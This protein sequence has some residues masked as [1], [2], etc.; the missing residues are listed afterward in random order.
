MAYRQ[1]DSAS[2]AAGTVKKL[3]D[4]L[5]LLEQLLTTSKRIYECDYL[6]FMF[7]G[8]NYLV[9]LCSATF[10]HLRFTWTV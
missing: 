7:S 2:H 6:Q 4:K 8:L 9:I 3:H 1:T 10:V 5:M